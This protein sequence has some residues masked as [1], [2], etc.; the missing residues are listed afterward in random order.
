MAQDVREGVKHVVTPY[1]DVEELAS[2]GKF[3]TSILEELRAIGSKL[4]VKPLIREYVDC[5]GRIHSIIREYLKPD[6]AKW[7]ETI[8]NVKE[9]FRNAGG[10]DSCAVAL[11][12]LDDSNKAE[13]TEVFGDF[14][15]RH[16]ELGNRNIGLT[17]FAKQFVSSEV[18]EK[19]DRHQI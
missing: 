16:E 6:V 18:L 10:N 19:G 7:K 15:K 13:Y 3:K 4:D 1:T 9:R 2:D 5:I 14:I 12:A 8:E 17:H 11:V